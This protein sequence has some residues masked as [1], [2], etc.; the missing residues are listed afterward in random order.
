M[1]HCDIAPFDDGHR[2]RCEI[3]QLGEAV[4]Y[5]SVIAAWRDDTGFRRFFSDLLRDVPFRAFRWETPPLTSANRNQLFECVVVDSPDLVVAPDPYTFARHF[6][7]KPVNSSATFPNLG[8]DAIL[9]APCPAQPGSDYAHF[10]AFLRHAEDAAQQALWRAVATAVDARLGDRPLW[11]SSAGGGVA[12]LHLRLDDRPKYYVH[13][14][15]RDT[16]FA[17]RHDFDHE[18]N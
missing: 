10:A 18:T 1:W 9:V 8:G 17:K 14:P 11:L 12:W 16:G 2:L 4:S 15:Y 7:G 3:T 5:A 13:A 6:A